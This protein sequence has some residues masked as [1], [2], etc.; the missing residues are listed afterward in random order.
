[1]RLMVLMALSAVFLSFATLTEAAQPRIV[2]ADGSITETVYALEAQGSLVGVDTTSNYPAQVQ[3]LP[4]VGYLRALPFEGVLSLRPDVLLTTVEAAPDKTLERLSQAGVD[5]IKL[6][7]A[8]SPA[9]TMARIRE[10][11]RIL[12]KQAQ[13]NAIIDDIRTRVERIPLASE[14]KSV[15]VLFLMAAG[16]HG[17]MIAGKG[18]AANALLKALGA[19]NAMAEVT[20]YKPANREALLASQP[21]AIVVAESRPGQ[22][23]ITQWPQLAALNAWRQGRHYVGDSML[24]LGFGPRL[25]QAMEEV[26]SMLAQ[27]GQVA[28]NDH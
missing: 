23:D 25:P 11:G 5:V 19:S 14:G 9:D 15:R 13:A 10:V 27:V 22:F 2:S 21:D 16:N 6:P 7:V 3:S 26:A 17:V 1:M 28:R 12:G 24:L 20:G 8:R 18:T 4:K